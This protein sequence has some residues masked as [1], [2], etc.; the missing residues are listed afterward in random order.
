MLEK[1]K[2]A[3]AKA[4]YNIDD[5]KPKI[6][7]S[8]GFMKGRK[9]PENLD[10]EHKIFNIQSKFS[11]EIDLWGKWNAENKE[12]QELIKVESYTKDAPK[13]FQSMR[14]PNLVQIQLY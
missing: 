13:S 2:Q 11:W 12:A 7:S 6:S 9:I 8:V 3:E 14:L 10:L 4:G 5:S 1:V